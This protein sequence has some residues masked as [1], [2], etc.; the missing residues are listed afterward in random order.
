MSGGAAAKQRLMQ[1]L[2]VL[3]KEKW[4]NIELQNGD[5]FKWSIALMVVNPESA[6]N[7]GYFKAEMG[8]SDK[9]PFLP[10]TFK[11]IRP[12]YHP[13]IYTD[14]KVCISILHPPGEDEQSGELASER[15]SPLQGVESVLRSVLLLLDD[16]EIS[17]PA[18]VDA[19]VMYRDNRTH[20]NI[21]ASE[22]VSISQKDIPDGFVMPKTLES[23]PP[24]KLIED[25]NFW[26]ESDGEEDDFG[27]SDSSGEDF[28]MD[29]DEEEGDEDEAEDEEEE[30]EEK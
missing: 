20:Y 21:K 17:S 10:P 6:F 18:N 11:F 22:A 16:P 5:L 19:S 8:F 3:E 13:N 23:A 25:D 30:E 1:E 9:Y 15:W 28:E 24:E 12:I 29:E 26:N 14:G 2:K 27:A 7:G 4:L